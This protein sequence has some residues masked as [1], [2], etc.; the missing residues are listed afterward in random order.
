M[1]FI[2]F[3][4]MTT[5]KILMAAPRCIFFVRFSFPPKLRALL[6]GSTV[7]YCEATCIWPHECISISHHNRICCAPRAAGQVVPSDL[8]QLLDRN[9]IISNFQVVEHIILIN[10]KTLNNNETSQRKYSKSIKIQQVN[11]NTASQ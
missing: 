10:S 9:N 2:R 3:T 8:S 4:L 1:L 5:S 11:K 6:L 7:L